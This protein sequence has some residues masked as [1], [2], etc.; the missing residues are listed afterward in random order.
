MQTKKPKISLLSLT[1]ITVVSVDSIRNLPAAAK[2]GSVLVSFYILAAFFFLIPTALVSAELAAKHRCSGG[3]YTWVKNE[4][5]DNLAVFAIWLQWIE[6]IIW[7]PTILSFVVGTIIYVV[8]PEMADNKYFIA[9]SIIVIFW[10]LTLINLGGISASARF[11]NFCTIAGLIFPMTLIIW[12]GISWI[13]HGNVSEISLSTK[14][15]LPNFTNTDL[16]VSLT[17]IMLSFSGIEIATVHAADVDNPQNKFPK[18]LLYAST[19]ILTTLILGSLSIAIVIPNNQI[20]LVTGIVQAFEIFFVAHNMSWMLPI[21]AITLAIGAA[22]GVSN[23]IIAPTKGLLFAADDKNL[24]TFFSKRNKKD[25]PTVL[26]YGQA[27]IVT[28]ISLIFLFA[29]GIN[30]SYWILTVIAIQLYMMMYIIMFITFIKM[31]QTNNNN[32]NIYFKVPG[33]KYIA[34][35][36]TIIGISGCIITLFVSFIPPEGMEMGSTKLYFI[37][38][39]VTVVIFSL[40]PVFFRKKLFSSNN[41]NCKS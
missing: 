6:N 12:L 20:N 14:D 35:L 38:L 15:I 39:L 24:P 4:F 3:I 9:S 11:S 7:Y 10:L 16:W 32:N 22:G 28:M 18:A 2:F 41:S 27:L 33:N 17:A 30:E 29:P 40:P 19:I 31:R 36:T 25:A 21:I 26:L 8:A 34:W 5:G 37:K 13:I 23:W 1:M